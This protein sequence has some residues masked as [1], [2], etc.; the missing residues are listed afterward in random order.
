MCAACDSIEIHNRNESFS[1]PV[2]LLVEFTSEKISVA[3]DSI[4]VHGRH[5]SFL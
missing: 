5:E 2:H 4:K 1:R 3:G